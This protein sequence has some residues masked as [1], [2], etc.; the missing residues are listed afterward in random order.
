MQE[1]AGKRISNLDGKIFEIIRLGSGVL[2]YFT[3]LVF[4]LAPW[5]EMGLFLCSYGLIGGEVVYKA[6]RN[7]FR[8][9]VFD[10]NMLM[11]I[12]TLGA[13]AV[14]EYPEAVA[15]M[16]F[17]QVGELFQDFAVDRSRGSIQALLAIR[18]DYANVRREG[19][20]V[21]VNPEEVTIGEEIVIKPGERVP[22]DGKIVEGNSLVDTAPLTGEALPRRLGEGDS[23]LSGC[24]NT[25]GLLVVEV[26][27]TYGESTVAKILD[28]VQNAESRKAPTEHFITK[29][30]R[31]YTPIVVGVAL[32]LAILPPLFVSGAVFSTWLYRG[33][34]FLV[35]SCPCALVISIPLSFFGGIGAA[36]RKGILVKGGNYLE[37]LHKVDTVIFDKTGTMTKGAFQVGTVNPVNGYTAEEVL[38][39]AAQAESFSTHPIAQSIVVAA[40]SMVAALTEREPDAKVDSYE[41]IAGLGVRAVF[42]D[43]TILVGNSK[44]MQNE[45]VQGFQDGE[46]GTGT[47]IHVAV[48]NCYIGSMV[49]ADQLKEDSVEALRKMRKLGVRQLVMLTGDNKDAAAQVAAR[50]QVDD[51]QAELL[52]Q[53]KVAHLERL[54]VNKGKGS[55]IFLGDGINDAPVLARADVGI[56]MGG[57]GSDAAIEAA[58][59]VIMTDEPSKL[60]TAIQIAGQTKQVVWQNI[61]L[62]LTVKGVVLALGAAGFATMWQAVFADVGVALL[63]VFNAMRVLRI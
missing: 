54:Y 47:V 13:F 3:V 27:K 53:D 46:P 41:E 56:A 38:S 43:R 63:A 31:Y 62:A 45:A 61:I 36:A 59:V 23:I 39:W 19:Q 24:V 18:P 34:I 6:V 29:F 1:D 10:E 37:A 15:V 51:F 5:M 9:R 33:L 28:L 11:T 58:D 25:T 60:A 2:L 32:A 50:L 30:A 26:L 57:L 7:L 22:L 20:L 44:L 4:Q 14:R 16:L 17:Y 12:A 35:I 48:D 49:I 42:G 55:L 52:P 21:C 8:G 40:N